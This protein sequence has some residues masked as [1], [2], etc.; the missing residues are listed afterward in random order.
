V[1]ILASSAT[2][3]K[4]LPTLHLFTEC[5]DFTKKEKKICWHSMLSLHV[6]VVG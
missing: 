1:S 6:D 5:V 2:K 3:E 4:M